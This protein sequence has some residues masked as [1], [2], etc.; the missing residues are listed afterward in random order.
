[1]IEGVA[2]LSSVGPSPTPQS[3]A[4]TSPAPRDF[5]EVKENMKAVLAD[6]QNGN[7]AKRFMEDQAA[8][9]PSS[10]NC[11]QGRGTPHRGNRPQLRELFSWNSVDDDYTEGSVA[12]TVAQ[13]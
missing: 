1:M 10:R 8:G 13:Q 6:I 9:A 2:S 4:T 7:F 11:A 5:P 12:Q 3:T